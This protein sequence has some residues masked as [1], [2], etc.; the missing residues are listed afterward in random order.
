VWSDDKLLGV[1]SAKRLTE[2]LATAQRQA[3]GN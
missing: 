3:F 2:R 1:V